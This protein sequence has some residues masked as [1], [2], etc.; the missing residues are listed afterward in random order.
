MPCNL[1][2]RT[3]EPN[4]D[5]GPF[6]SRT[7]IIANNNLRKFSV[8]GAVHSSTKFRAPPIKLARM[9]VGTPC[10]LRNN[11]FGRKRARNKLHLRKR[12][13]QRTYACGSGAEM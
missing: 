11:R 8:A 10:N 9:D 13:I 5:C 1:D 7:C 3:T 4:P 12:A 2:L 6:I